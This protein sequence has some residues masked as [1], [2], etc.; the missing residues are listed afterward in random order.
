[1]ER[2]QSTNTEASN[3]EV[4][5][6]LQAAS[7]K[8]SDDALLTALSVVIRANVEYA[9]GVTELISS[10]LDRTERLAEIGQELTKLTAKTQELINSQQ[11]LLNAINSREDENQKY[12]DKKLS[13]L[14][15][16][17]GLRYDG[18]EYSPSDKFFLTVQK[19][20]KS[21][22]LAVIAGAVIVWVVKLIYSGLVEK[23][24][25]AVGSIGK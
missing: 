11:T 10:D 13:P 4:D 7:Q 24:T 15:K 25:S 23:A 12:L 5:A 20:L 17:A 9:K 22:L 21:R 8:V 1:M 6:Y 2:K 19:A 14:Y 18:T 16:E 3:P